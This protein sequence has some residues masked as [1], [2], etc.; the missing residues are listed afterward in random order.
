MS[1]TPCYKRSCF[2]LQPFFTMET[3]IILNYQTQH[4]DKRIAPIFLRFRAATTTGLWIFIWFVLNGCLASGRWFDFLRDSG[5]SN[6]WVNGAGIAF[7]VLPPLLWVLFDGAAFRA[8]YGMRQVDIFFA[9]RTGEKIT[10]GHC[11][12]RILLGIALLPI[13]P[14][15]IIVAVSDS[16]NRSLADRMCGTAVWCSRR[17]NMRP[18][19]KDWL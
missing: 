16:S 8:T 5:W 6:Q 15:S 4:E 11:F 10:F 2:Q 14:V 13:F 18:G 12:V 1:R 17:F 3:P 7:Q 19:L 9:G